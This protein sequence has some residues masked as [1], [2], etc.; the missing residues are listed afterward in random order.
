MARDLADLSDEELIERQQAIGKA[1]AEAEARHKEEQT[2]VQRELDRRS[3]AAR[4]SA[5]EADL[6]ELED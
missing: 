1:R 5:L 2:A 3:K 6:A 4:R